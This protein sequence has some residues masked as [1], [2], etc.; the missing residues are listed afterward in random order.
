MQDV[1]YSHCDY[2]CP[3]P[4]IFFHALIFTL[5]CV[6]PI[7]FDHCVRPIGFEHCVLTIGFDHSTKTWQFKDAFGKPNKR[8]QRLDLI[9][10]FFK[11][12]WQKVTKSDIGDR[13]CNEKCN[14]THSKCFSAQFLCN[15][16]F[17][18][19]MTPW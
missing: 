13:C 2:R 5:T 14:V 4:E 11:S 1:I 18:P 12:T 9:F 3:W 7:G 8:A 16:V 17:A 6:R 15:L 10:Q 19:L